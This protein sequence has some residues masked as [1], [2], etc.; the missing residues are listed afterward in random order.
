MQSGPDANGNLPGVEHLRSLLTPLLTLAFLVLQPQ[1]WWLVLGFAAATFVMDGLAERS[2]PEK[3]QPPAQRDARL[4]DALLYALFAMHWA[5]LYLAVRLVGEIGWLGLQAPVALLLLLLSSSH[6]VIVAHELIHRPGAR[7]RW[8]GRLLLCSVF[9]EH[10][11]TEHLR[12]HH[13]RVGTVDDPA[14]ALPG[15]A[16]WPYFRR[17]IPA[18]LVNAWRLER[19]RIQGRRPAPLSPLHNRVLQGMLLEVGLVVGVFAAFGWNGLSLLLANAAAVLVI[20]HAVFYFQ[21][22]GLERDGAVSGVHSWDTVSRSNLFSMIGMSR[23]ADHH[24]NPGRPYH[25][26]RYVESSPKLPRAYGGMVWLSV[27]DNARFQRLMNEALP[28]AGG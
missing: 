16:F 10:F 17:N 15:E 27:V 3:R 18:Q 4:F 19:A 26:L 7:E 21:H 1:Q 13:A 23:H 2:A 8:M 24:L 11:F 22:W 9:Y 20:T 5:N 28:E 6:A 12:T 25:L 14:T